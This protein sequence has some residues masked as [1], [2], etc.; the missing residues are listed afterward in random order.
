MKFTGVDLTVGTKSALALFSTTFPGTLTRTRGLVAGQLDAAAADSRVLVAIG[1]ILADT[2]AVAAGAASMPGPASE[3]NAPWFWHGFLWLSS[4]AEAA[5]N[6]NSLF[7][8][9]EIDSKAMRKMK[10]SQTVAA[11]IEVCDVVDQGGTFDVMLG[12]RALFGA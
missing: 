12:A 5:V 6:Q 8:R 11:V 9:L 4:G 7:H 1:L 2:R 10:E 3:G